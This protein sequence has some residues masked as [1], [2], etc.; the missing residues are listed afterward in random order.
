MFTAAEVVFANAVH[1]RWYVL[2]FVIVAI[3]AIVAL[4]GAVILA[5]LE[6]ESPPLLETV[7]VS[8]LAYLIGNRVGA[9]ANETKPKDPPQ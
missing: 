1:S 8:A 7:V 4:I 5:V 9:A 3:L 6:I 2:Q